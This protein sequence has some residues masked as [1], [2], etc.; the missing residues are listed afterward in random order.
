M[1]G[2]LP[3]A[4][5]LISFR[6]LRWRIRPHIH[7]I[8][9]SPL[10]SGGEALIIGIVLLAVT[11]IARFHITLGERQ[12]ALFVALLTSMCWYTIRLRQ[13]HRRWW[14]RATFE[15]GYGL[16]AALVV[17]GLIWLMGIKLLP[18]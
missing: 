9:C 18:G 5:R 11:W 3:V 7:L 15:V 10:R 1:G 13:G 12:N 4:H 14:K 16:L 6:Q 8:A 17:G 2:G